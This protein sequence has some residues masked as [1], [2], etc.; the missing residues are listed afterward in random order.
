MLEDSHVQADLGGT[1]VVG[2]N[3]I[4]DY[5][6]STFFPDEDSAAD[7]TLHLFDAVRE[8]GEYEA[9]FAK[10][11]GAVNWF[12]T[13]IGLNYKEIEERWREFPVLVVKESV[14]N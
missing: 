6:D 3:A 1:S 10:A 8:K 9:F 11:Y 12:S 7:I 4:S 2:P 14:S 13:T 5:I